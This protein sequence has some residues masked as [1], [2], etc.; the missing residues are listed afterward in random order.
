MSFHP[1]LPVPIRVSFLR[2]YSRCCPINNGD[3]KAKAPIPELRVC[4]ARINLDPANTGH[5]SGQLASDK[6]SRAP[7]INRA[8]N[9]CQG[10]HP[11]ERRAGGVKAQKAGI[12]GAGRSRGEGGPGRGLW[13]ACS[14]DRAR[15]EARGLSVP[16][17]VRKSL[18]LLSIYPPSGRKG[19]NISIWPEGGVEKSEGDRG[20]EEGEAEKRGGGRKRRVHEHYKVTNMA[21]PS[22]ASSLQRNEDAL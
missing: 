3:G 7:F 10:A 4:Y 9:G 14:S 22:L 12:L 20:G 6:V 8:P 18:P 19:R 16:L 21:P 15:W 5:S 2:L 17:H 13:V 11:R 1:S